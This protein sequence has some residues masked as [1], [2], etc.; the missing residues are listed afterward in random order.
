MGLKRVFAARFLAEGSGRPMSVRWKMRNRAMKRQD[1]TG[2]IGRG[3][4]VVVEE[5]IEVLLSDE[6]L[7]SILKMAA[8][9]KKTALKK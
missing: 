3:E 8:M 2:K 4:V 1:G 5:G 7:E 9:G 6:V